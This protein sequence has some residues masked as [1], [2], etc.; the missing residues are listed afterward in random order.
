MGYVFWSLRVFVKLNMARYVWR[1]LGKGEEL[2]G[3]IPEATP[4]RT[5]GFDLV[6]IVSLCLALCEDQ[7][8]I[9]P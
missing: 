9:S 2:G 1:G 7:S 6:D 8:W 5:I 3:Y 4:G